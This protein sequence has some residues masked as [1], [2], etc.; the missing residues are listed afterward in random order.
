MIVVPIS[1]GF[2]I[3]YLRTVA[4]REKIHEEE[5]KTIATLDERNKAFAATSALNSI[6]LQTLDFDLL[7]K[8]IANS[9]P[10]FLGYQTGV[11]AVV[12]HTT[13]TL[14]RIAISESSGGIAALK[15]LEIPFSSIAISLDEKENFCIKALEE[16]KVYTTTKLY[17]VLRPAISEINSEKVQQ[18]MGTKTTLIY[19]IYSV[20]DKKPIGTFIVSVNKPEDQITEFE[21][22][23]LSTF[24]DGVRIALVN[25]T[26]YTS[27]QKTTEEL[28][29]ANERLQELDK[30]KDDFVSIASHELRTPM[31]VIKSYLWMVLNKKKLAKETKRY[32]EK[33]KIAVDRLINLVNNMLNVSRIESG[34]IILQLAEMSLLDLAQE[35]EEEIMPKIKEL[36]L[37]LET[38]KTKL[39]NVFCDKE[40]VREIFL[41]LVGNAMKFTPEGG[42][43]TVSF[44]IKDNFLIT[45]VTDTGQGIAPEDLKKL[46]TKFG[47]LQ[48]S[49]SAMAEA[50]GTGLGLYISKSIINLHKGAITVH[51]DGL[52]KGSRFSFSLPIAG[53]EIAKQVAADA[54]K[55]EEDSTKS[56]INT[57]PIK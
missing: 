42:T 10:Q 23:T 21:K 15:S 37:K 24:V 31:T 52:G 44:E 11:L 22:Q 35:V 41:N 40:K 39:P 34:R 47:R 17:D 54:P 55:E 4:A 18:M 3:Y 2:I 38:I 57:T 53:T 26:L 32:L 13:H 56:F 6:I 27:L 50:R 19:P 7:A 14:K 51:S 36:N 43:I 49:Y 29:I 8:R 45:S 9:I 5:Q 25:A 12:D 33:A 1:V 28:R 46:F 30:L 16:N 48:N 20:I